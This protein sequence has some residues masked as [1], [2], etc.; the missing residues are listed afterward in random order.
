M[1]VPMVTLFALYGNQN[2]YDSPGHGGS[3]LMLTIPA[4]GVLSIIA[5]FF[6]V[7]TLRRILSKRLA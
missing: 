5:F 7:S 1:I 4:A 6:L 3:L 2:V